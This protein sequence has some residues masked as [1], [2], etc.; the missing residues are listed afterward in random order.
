MDWSR[1]NDASRQSLEDILARRDSSARLLRDISQ[2]EQRR[3]ESERNFALNE[4]VRRGAL[5]RQVKQDA[6]TAE[7][8]DETRKLGKITRTQAGARLLAPGSRITDPQEVADMR[9]AGLGSRLKEILRPTALPNGASGPVD[10]SDFVEGQQEFLG[11]ADQLDTQA[12]AEAAQARQE[13]LQTQRNTQNEM[14]EGRLR[15]SQGA[16]DLARERLVFDRDKLNRPPA[17]RAPGKTP[18][19]IQADAA[20][21]S[22]GTAQGKAA[23]TPP[24]ALASL[25]N[26]VLGEPAPAQPATSSASP[27]VGATKQ[28]PNGR[29]AVFDGQGWVA[30]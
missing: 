23:G 15:N 18:Q 17:P 14:A 6:T 30:Q 2:E 22:A 7:D 25:R 29:K 21:R 3:K 20:A 5:A 1:A 28:F 12:R 8:R 27:A 19:E 11:T 13:A 24:G 4:E 10:S 16:S 9:E 26:M